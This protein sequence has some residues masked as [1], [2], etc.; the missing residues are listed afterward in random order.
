MAGV[1]NPFADRCEQLRQI[2]CHPM[3]SSEWETLFRGQG[4]PAQIHSME[5]LRQKMVTVK[6]QR[7]E[8]V[9]RRIDKSRRHME[10]AERAVVVLTA[11][12]GRLTRSGSVALQDYSEATE[13]RIVEGD[14]AVRLLR[15]VKEM[16]QWK[17]RLGVE[18]QRQHEAATR[19][20]LA[21]AR[22][23][24]AANETELEHLRRDKDYFEGVLQ[25]IGR[26]VEGA[27]CVICMADSTTLSVTKCGHVYCQGCLRDWLQ[28]KADCPLCK[29]ALVRWGD[30]ARRS[31]G[32]AVGRGRTAAQGSQCTGQIRMVFQNG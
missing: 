19:Q 17:G 14:R 7:L 13:F 25:D 15:G 20:Y 9:V 4:G 5:Q 8:A 30:S 3:V 18:Q 22:Q 24:L 32:G 11:A 10:A 29:A 31:C 1:S 26:R 27:E 2:C 6:Q 21:E 28:Q 16:V 23:T 12:G